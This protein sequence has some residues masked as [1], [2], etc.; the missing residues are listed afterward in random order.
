MR[1]FSTNTIEVRTSRSRVA[2]LF[3][4]RI[5]NFRW[6]GGGAGADPELKNN[7]YFILKITL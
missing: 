2:A 5:Q 6:G 3:R 4:V 1:P 7:F